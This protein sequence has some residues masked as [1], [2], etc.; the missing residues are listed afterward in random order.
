MVFQ[1]EQDLKLR[2]TEI[3]LSAEDK[4]YGLKSEMKFD[5]TA[6]SIEVA[7]SSPEGVTEIKSKGEK[8]GEKEYKCKNKIRTVINPFYPILSL[9]I[10]ENFSIF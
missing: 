10:L 3:N 6:P 2:K 8:L 9:E 1:N 5:P 7:I 4:K